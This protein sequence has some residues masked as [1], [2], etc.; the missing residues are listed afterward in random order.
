[1]PLAGALDAAKVATVAEEVV[2]KEAVTPVGKPDAAKVIAPAKPL[3]GEILMVSV[4]VCLGVNV[5]ELEAALSEKSDRPYTTTLAL[6][7]PT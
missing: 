4:M 7:V 2:A 3:T 5:S 6:A 1:M